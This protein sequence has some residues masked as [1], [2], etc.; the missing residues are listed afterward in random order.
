MNV[1]NC[2]KTKHN[3]KQIL[4]KITHLPRRLLLLQQQEYHQTLTTDYFQP[5][6][7]LIQLQAIQNKKSFK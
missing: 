3:I 2:N 1:S 5:I 4:Q 7:Q 6:V